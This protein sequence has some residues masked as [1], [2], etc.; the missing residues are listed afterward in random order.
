MRLRPLR[1]PTHQHLSSIYEQFP[2]SLQR[3]NQLSHALYD[4]YFDAIQR[5]NS[6]HSTITDFIH[7][8]DFSLPDFGLGCPLGGVIVNELLDRRLL[9][10]LARIEVAEPDDFEVA[11]HCWF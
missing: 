6:Q 3:Y 1:Y 10:T 4:H 8:D 11:R 2:S 9:P 7:Q 5:L